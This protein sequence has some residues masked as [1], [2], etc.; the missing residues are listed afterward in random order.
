MRKQDPDTTKGRTGGQRW[1]WSGAGGVEGTGGP[2]E[3]THAQRLRSMRCG[4]T[5]AADPQ[6]HL[7][8][9]ASHSLRCTGQRNGAQ[10]GLRRPGRSQ[11]PRT[12]DGECGASRRCAPAGRGCTP[13]FRKCRADT[14]P[15]RG[16]RKGKGA[17]ERRQRRREEDTEEDGDSEKQRKT[18]EDTKEKRER[19]KSELR[20]EKNTVSLLSREPQIPERFTSARVHSHSTKPVPLCPLYGFPVQKRENEPRFEFSGENPY[21][22][23]TGCLQAA[24]RELT[25]RGAFTFWR[26]TAVPELTGDLQELTDAG[27]ICGFDFLKTTTN[28]QTAVRR[29]RR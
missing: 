7:A 4:R 23:L 9:A 20:G 24:Y 16:A 26:Q 17:R 8:A 11:R 21:R 19:E 28:S 5:C 29:K 25:D 13:A 10:Y 12:A 22:Q 2:T 6:A 3:T 14:S 18:S 27:R 1:G 15:Q